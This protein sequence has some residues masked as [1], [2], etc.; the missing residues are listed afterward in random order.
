V[1]ADLP[2]HTGK[3]VALIDTRHR[4]FASKISLGL[5][6]TSIAYGYRSAWIGAYDPSHQTAWLLKV[7]STQTQLPLRLEGDDGEGPLAVAVG[8]GRVWVITSRGNLLGID[9]RTMQIVHRVRMS[10][11]MPTLLAVGAGSVWTTNNN[12]YSVSQINPSTNT[13]V[14]TIP[15]GRY[16][17]TPCGIMATR[18]AVFVASGETTCS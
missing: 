1:I 11:Q 7:S 5:P 3:S 18:S 15:F 2:G 16:D 8:D 4:R 9:P 10:V 14:R 17:A 6:T 13:I 12:G